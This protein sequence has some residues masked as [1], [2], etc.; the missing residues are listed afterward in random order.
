MLLLPLALLAPICGCG[1]GPSAVLPPK[2]DA[3]NA[4][5][6]AMEAY[7][8]DGNGFVEGEELENAPGLRAAL[9]TLDLDKDGKVDENEV[10]ERILA[11]RSTDVGITTIQC[12]VMLDG[13]PLSG[14]SITFDPEEFLGEEIQAATAKTGPLGEFFPLIPKENLPTP[15]T[16]VGIQIGL[17]KVR[18]S[19][20]VNG[21]EQIPA[22][23]NTETVLGQEVS[24]D[25]PAIRRHSVVFKLKSK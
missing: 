1:G 17:Y 12:S 2:I 8:T 3:S 7:D 25:D 21:E 18:V 22:K 10:A 5:A 14:A 6:L 20:V 23:Y 19:K 4:A 15:T 16:P 24:N 9:T 13:R 11:W